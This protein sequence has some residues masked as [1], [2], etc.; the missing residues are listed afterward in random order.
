LAQA[1][2]QLKDVEQALAQLEERWLDLSEQIER[3]G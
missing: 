2:R 1:G 3:C